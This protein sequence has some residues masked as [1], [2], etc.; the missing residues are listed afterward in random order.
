MNCRDSG[1]LTCRQNSSHIRIQHSTLER[2][3]MTPRAL[4]ASITAIMVA[5]LAEPP[6]GVVD[7]F[8]NTLPGLITAPQR[9]TILYSTTFAAE[10]HRKLCRYL[11]QDL[12]SSFRRLEHMDFTTTSALIRFIFEHLTQWHNRPSPTTQSHVELYCAC[13][14]F[15]G[16]HFRFVVEFLLSLMTKYASLVHTQ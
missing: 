12:A 7:R 6:S 4:A 14:N 1:R 10:L 5:F 8:C 3:N 9:E 13:T 2:P 11:F 16:C 15:K